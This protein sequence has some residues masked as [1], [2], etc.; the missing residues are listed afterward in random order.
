MP[1]TASDIDINNIRTNLEQLKDGFNQLNQITN[2]TEY[3]E[4]FISVKDYSEFIDIY[5]EVAWDS[6]I[7]LNKNYQVIFLIF[8]MG[9]MLARFLG[10]IKMV[11]FI[12]LQE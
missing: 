11:I 2:S 8:F 4:G 9:L 6:F 7:R 10:H 5:S 3:V 12:K 1:D